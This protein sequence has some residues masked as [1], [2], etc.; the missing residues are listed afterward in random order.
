VFKDV[1]L[2]LVLAVSVAAVL[3]EEQR[4]ALADEPVPR[5]AAVRLAAAGQPPE[6]TQAAVVLLPQA[7][8]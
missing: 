5:L 7:A 2:L 6:V 8:A 1:V 3:Q 4:E